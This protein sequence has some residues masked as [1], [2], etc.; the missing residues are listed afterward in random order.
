MFVFSPSQNNYN[1]RRVHSQRGV[2]LI[3]VLLIVTVVAGLAVKYT[4][5]YQLS[6]ARAESRWHGLQSRAFLSGTEAIASLLFEQADIDGETDYL[7][8]PWGN[9][10]PIDD[11]GISGYAQLTDATNQLNLNDLGGVLANDKSMGNPERYTEPQRRFIRLLQTFPEIPVSQQQAEGL[12]EAVVDWMDIDDSESGAYGAESSYYQGLAT[13]Y[14]A[15]N[16]MFISVEE[17]RLIRGFDELPE[18]VSLVLPFIT[19]LPQ[20]SV[21]INI[22][23]IVVTVTQPEAGLDIR[24]NNLL[25]ALGSATSLMPVGDNEIIQLLSERPETGF[26]DMT[27]LAE[28][29]KR[30]FGNVVLDTT[31]INSKTD[32]FWLT[33]RVQMGDQRRNV[34]SLF[35]RKGPGNT[36]TV[37]SRHDVFEL[38]ETNFIPESS[39]K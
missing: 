15:A 29:W 8:E 3:A 24:A 19:V 20:E 28:E 22:N 6:L 14:F 26:S 2:I 30:L 39:N 7:G 32:F 23:T 10:V 38:P 11:E 35:R 13:P 21:G 16:Q 31:G 4:A 17:L 33:S 1:V 12:L 37:I 25:R 18:L 36:I 5:D 9:E 34:R 27:I